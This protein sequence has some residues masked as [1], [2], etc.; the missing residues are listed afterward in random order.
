MGLKERVGVEG[1][2]GGRE[3]GR[4]GGGSIMGE[5]FSCIYTPCICEDIIL[6]YEVENSCFRPM[7]YVI[8]L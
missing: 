6:P 3:G 8:L 2:R 5:K 7:Q 4:E 1:G